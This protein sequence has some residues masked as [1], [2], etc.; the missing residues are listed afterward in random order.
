MKN[1]K[2]L[3]ICSLILITLSFNTII[4]GQCPV[5]FSYQQDILDYKKV[6][7]TVEAQQ[8]EGFV[9]FEWFFDDF[10]VEVEQLNPVFDF[11]EDGVHEVIFTFLTY[12]SCYDTIIKHVE[13]FPEEEYCHANFQYSINPSNSRQVFFTDSSYA[14]SGIESLKWLFGAG[15]EKYGQQVEHVFPSPGSFSVCLQMTEISG[16]FNEK[17]K[18]IQIPEDEEDEEECKA[19]FSFQLDSN[20]L[21]KFD[22]ID[23]STSSAGPIVSHHWDFGDGA[24]SFSQNP[25]HTYQYGGQKVV[26]LIIATANNCLDT[27]YESLQVPLGDEEDEEDDCQADFS[28]EEDSNDVNKYNFEDNSSAER[29]Y[30]NTWQWDFGA[31]N[32]SNSQNPSNYYLNSGSYPVCLIIFTDLGC[33]DTICETLQVD[34]EGDES[35]DC[36]ANFSGSEDQNDSTIINFVSTSTATDSIVKYFW[37]LNQ[38]LESEESEYQYQLGSAGNHQLCLGIETENGCKDTLCI[39]LIV[40]DDTLDIHDD[41]RENLLPIEG[42]LASIWAE[43]NLGNPLEYFFS[44]ESASASQTTLS[45]VWD[46]EN[47]IYTSEIFAIEF[48]SSGDKNIKLS[49]SG[50]GCDSEVELK[51]PVGTQNSCAVAFTFLVDSS[52]QNRVQFALSGTTN[53]TGGFWQ[54]GDGLQSDKLY[55]IHEFP[56]PGIYNVCVTAY[57]SITGCQT[58]F[59]K[60]VEI[61]GDNN[62]SNCF[63]NY[64][65]QIDNDT[66]AF[67]NKSQGNYTNVH[68]AFGDGTYS[69]EENPTKIYTQSE[70]YQVCL[71]VFDSNTGCVSEYCQAITVLEDSND[72]FCQ[73]DFNFFPIGPKKFVFDNQSNGNFTDVKWEFNGGE[74]IIRTYEAEFEFPSS[75][76][77]EVCLSIFDSLSGCFNT[78]CKFI[79]VIDTSVVNC[80]AEFDFFKEANGNVV[81]NS[82]AVGSYTNVHFSLGDAMH[83]DEEQFSHQYQNSGHYE[84]CMSIYDSISGCQDQVCE[85]VGV[86]LDTVSVFCE[87]K[88]DFYFDE[89]GLVHVENL[90]VGPFTNVH[91]DFGDGNHSNDNST[92]H[93]FLNSGFYNI[94]LN[95]FD[96]VSGCHSSLCDVVNIQLDSL[97]KNCAADFNFMV[98]QDKVFF[99]N[100]SLGN[101]TNAHWKFGDW[102]FSNA[103]NPNHT[104]NTSGVYE[105]CLDIWD[106]VSGCQD[107]ICKEVIILKDAADALCEARFDK[108]QLANGEI[109]FQNVSIGN[110]T[111]VY[112]NLGNGDF[113]HHNDPTGNYSDEGVYNVSLMIWDSISGCQSSYSEE[114]VISENSDQVECHAKFEYFPINDSLVKFKSI[115]QGSYSNNRWDFGD[116]TFDENIGEV[117]HVYSHG[118]F[119]NVSFAIYDS[120]SGCHDYVFDNVE[121]F[122]DTTVIDCR[123]EFD[124][125]PVSSTA[126]VFNN[127]STGQFT[128]SYWKFSDGSKS[129]SMN[130]TYDF[131][132]SG[133]FG[134][135]LTVFDSI[136]QCQDEFCIDIP[137]VHDSTVYCDAHFEYFV[138]GKTVKFEPEISGNITG[139]IWDFNDG[140]NSNDSFPQYTYENDGVYEVCLTVFDS[141]SQCFNTYC[142]FVSIITDLDN[143]DEYVEADFSYY[144]NPTNSKV[145]FKDESVGNPTSWYWD[146]GDSDSAGVVQNPI[147][148][149]SEDGLYEVCLTVKNN[150][151]GQETKCQI[152]TVGDV[153]NACFAKFDYYANSVTATAHFDNISLGKI[154]D[155]HWDFGDSI[156][157]VQYQ[158][159]HTYADTGYYATCLTVS[160]DSG[161]IR[162]FCKEIRVGNALENKCLIG[163]VWPGDANLDTEANHYDI[164]PIGIHYGEM[165]PKRSIISSDW[166]GHESQDWSKQLWGDVNNKHGDA[167]GDGIIN[168]ADILIVQENFAYSHPWQPR[169]NTTN[170]LSIDWDVDDIDVGETAVLTVSIPDT[171]DVSMYGLGF[172]IDLDPVVFDYGTLVFDFSDSWL[173]TEDDDLITFG[174]YDENKGQIYIAETRNDHQ[175]LT[176]N[177][178]LVKI[179]VTAIAN[180]SNTGAILTTEGG[181]TAQGDTVEFNGGEDG[182]DVNSMDDR[183]NYI[184]KDLVVFPNPTSDNVS[185]SLPTGDVSKDYVIE[186][187]DNI[188]SLLYS[189]KRSVGGIVIQSFKEYDS[190]IYTLKVTNEKVQYMQKIIVTK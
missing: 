154:A 48:P 94:C 102:A 184:I 175:E 158:P 18:V 180:S 76:H 189:T 82:K 74:D 71:N 166:R 116:G 164:L 78:I 152:I 128:N 161:C 65:Y 136:T 177:G 12:D 119:Y 170:Q 143:I 163:C 17:C 111:D 26:R 47:D 35:D 50:E 132:S 46:I 100:T 108:I 123:A 117:T 148:V 174:F 125:F 41:D 144:L 120:A 96:S 105:V 151:G 43:R 109:K 59:C 92:S 171:I 77:F 75:G 53:L 5:D 39:P 42:C 86:N 1:S 15:V 3:K 168:I 55:P 150:N 37:I 185:Y 19:E 7:F 135:C 190:G 79:D 107:N 126:I 68:Y 40:H 162:T 14:P 9:H 29:G 2:L 141:I 110:F 179:Y 134:A 34:I 51:V 83:S 114:V 139:W 80:R 101:T 173:G 22:F 159:A 6:T 73:A 133:L 106:S 155:Y 95:I 54:F 31:G 169:A 4:L 183:E 146:F 124:F 112:W 32:I 97:N 33:S 84:V 149:Y 172:E 81:F 157:S 118:G 8:V 129:Y 69:D 10:G 188:G 99:A 187:Y 153:S 89:N 113:A 186:L 91:W 85:I 67:T 147:Y 36:T 88:M 62:Q 24:N 49:I 98:L 27:T 131:N 182:T 93:E 13:I 16:C 28:F 52:N 45:H 70:A 140:F 103:S 115:A 38:S 58:Q 181:V 138:S 64:D 165:G 11:P 130:P 178:E 176:G 72:V 122:M 60:P 23:E 21:R 137:V 160:N 57:D 56:G 127:I 142:E 167:N 90:S 104:Y 87:A 63:A 61:D 145:H 25:S 20:V 44:S 66:V 156:T 121:L 30:I